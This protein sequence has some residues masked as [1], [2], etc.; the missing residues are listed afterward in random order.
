MKI[1]TSLA[2]YKSTNKT[3]VT[4]GTFDGVHIGHQKV[5]KRLVKDAKKN[6]ATS[7]LLTFFP[8]PRMVLQKDIGIKLINTIEEKTSLLESLGLDVLIIQEF[9]QEFSENSALDFVR[10]ILVNALNVSKLIIGYD[11]HF[12]K[13]REGNFEELKEFSYTYG[14]N[15]KKIKKQDISDIAVSSTKIRLAI[16]S[17]AIE[18]ANSYLNYTFPLTGIVEKGKSLG[19]QIGFPTANIKI[20]EQYKL[21]PKTGVYIV[22]SILNDTN[23]FGM[24]NI[25]YRP[26]VGGKHQT[27]ETH[28]FNYNENLYGKK[29]KIEVLKQLRDEEKFESIDDLKL[30]LQKDK[31]NS[32]TFI[33]TNFL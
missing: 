19:K 27:I 30:Q 14:F 3:F 17:G 29:L 5:I 4:I 25:G 6:E 2:N 12:G 18:K 16:E 9:T 11:H 10:N 21:I 8:H 32:L 1:Y 20:E 24:M 15:I 31:V 7:V 13:N 22:K 23:V 26:T 33:K 28:F